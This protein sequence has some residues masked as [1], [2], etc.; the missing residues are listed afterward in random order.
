MGA[1]MQPARH[2]WLQ[3][4]SGVACLHAVQPSVCSAWTCSR[5]CGKTPS[6]TA[7]A[8]PMRLTAAAS[9]VSA[10]RAS[11]LTV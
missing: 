4:R 9:L 2:Q 7:A 3:A 6:R 5:R 10:H 11:L 1:M 8:H